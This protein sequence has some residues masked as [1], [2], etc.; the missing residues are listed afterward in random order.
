MNYYTLTFLI[1]FI[2]V[3][4]NFALADDSGVLSGRVVDRETS[5]PVAYAYLHIEELNR[6]ITAHSDGTF[7]F[8]NLPADTYTLS[9]YRIGYQTLSQ[10]LTITDDKTTEITISLK[11]TV[12]NSDALE[13]IGSAVHSESNL[14]HASKT[15]SGT[16]LRKDLGTTLASTLDEIPGF[17]SRSMGSAPSRPVIRG[18]GGKRLLILQDGEK[19]G[20]VSS[21]S[22][23]HAVTV[24]PMAA[25]KIEIARGPA[26]LQYGANAIGGVINIVR[27]QIATVQPQHLHGTASLQGE[28]VNMGAVAGLETSLPLG[29]HIALKLDGNM[30][31]AQNIN[32][33]EGELKNSGILSTN[34]A[35]GLSYIQPWGHVG[36]ASSMYLNTYGIPP[37][38]NAGHPNGANIEMQ[39]YQAEVGSEIV[40]ENSVFKSIKADIS[41]KNYYHR[42]IESSGNIGTEFGM[43]T[44]NASIFTRHDELAFF[45]K[46]KIGLWAEA[47]N[48]AVQGARTPNSDSYSLSGYFI[49]AKD[50][51][52]LHLE[53]GARFDY[54]NTIPAQKDPISQI[55][56]IRERS[57][58]ALSS[59][60]SI[61]YNLGKGFHT[62]TALM[63]SFRAPSQEELYSEGP[64]LASYSYEVGNPDLEPE[65]GLGKELF[66]RYKTTT[67]RAELNLYHNSFDSYI[68]PRNTGSPSPRLPSLNI[69]QFIGV[70]AVF[71]GFE[72]SSQLQVLNSWALTGSV[73]YT[74]AHSKINN[75]N[76]SGWQPLPM[77]PPLQ[78]TGSIT[79]AEGDL[80]LGTKVHFAAKQSR[81]GEFE[82]L[83]NEYIVFDLFTQYRFQSGNLLHTFSLNIENLFNTTY[84]NHLSRIK[85]ITPEPGIGASLLY[86]VYF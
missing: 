38:P 43:L 63:H 37:D 72:V 18:L 71:Q 57:F 56:T 10:R 41:Y 61:I 4:P 39:K 86:R 42:E 5:E 66:L 45:D 75:T 79:Y 8:S 60:V 59:S 17:G 83:T 74:H 27:N 26:A 24:D 76:D 85:E 28:S 14:E 12:L 82:T 70:D 33:P 31:S 65:R 21:Q 58:N 77:I 32:T 1:L 50:I 11:P 40:L 78:G 35:M 29:K 44:G 69:Y 3:F 64:H 53:L 84:R 2:G 30:R 16:E 52:S 13:V 15:I 62:G 54:V 22:A 81:T 20:D 34:N 23:D 6:T 7:Q 73:S 19:T 55:G 9:V 49:E 47:K 36:L 48:Y 51:G 67:V 80:R 25:E 68:Y 46:G